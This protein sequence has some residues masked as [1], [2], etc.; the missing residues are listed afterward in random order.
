MIKGW[1]NAW[2]YVKWLTWFDVFGMVRKH[3]WFIITW[4]IVHNTTDFSINNDSIYGVKYLWLNFSHLIWL[5][6]DKIMKEMHW[7][8]LK[9]WHG[10]WVCDGARWGA[11]GCV[12]DA[13]GCD[14]LRWGAWLMRWVA[15]GC[16]GARWVAL[17]S[18]DGCIMVALMSRDGC[19]K[20]ALMTRD[21]E[22]LLIT[23]AIS[24]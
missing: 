17:M 24:Q 14:G 8:M 10:W 23:R 15:M 13:M 5:N 12:T 9:G 6:N 18:R 2:V 19:I 21:Y 1:K 4:V 11:M 20:V 22:W 3:D 7:C 16:D